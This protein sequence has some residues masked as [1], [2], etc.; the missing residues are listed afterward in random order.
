MWQFQFYRAIEIRSEREREA[1][2]QRLASAAR[3]ANLGGGPS[4]VTRIRLG[5]ALIAAET[6]RRLDECAAR[7]AL[8]RARDGQVGSLS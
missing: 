6:A 1:E 4:V 8:N 3:A 7:D 5:G 2:L